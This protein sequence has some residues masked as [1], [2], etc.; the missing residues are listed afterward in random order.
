[1]KIL[2]ELFTHTVNCI[3]HKEV[4]SLIFCHHNL[5]NVLIAFGVKKTILVTKLLI[6]QLF[7]KSY[8]IDITMLELAHKKR[9][10]IISHRTYNNIITMMK[11]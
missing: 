9:Y 3:I 10:S 5:F 2:Y 8:L 7:S 1:M 11:M 6:L 4:I